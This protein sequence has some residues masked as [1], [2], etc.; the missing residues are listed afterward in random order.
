MTLQ[1]NHGEQ[2]V[3]GNIHSVATKDPSKHL[4]FFDEKNGY[5]IKQNP[6]SFTK[7]PRLFVSCL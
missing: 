5:I 7:I 4:I 1:M 2:E 6:F 3:D